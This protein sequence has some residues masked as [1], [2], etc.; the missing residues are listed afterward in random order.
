MTGIGQAWIASTTAADPTERFQSAADA[1][2]SLEAIEQEVG[3]GHLRDELAAEQIAAWRAIRPT[4]AVIERI[5]RTRAERG[6][7]QYVVKT[8]RRLLPY[9]HGQ[10]A[11]HLLVGLHKAGVSND[12]TTRRGG[13][14]G[15]RPMTGGA[16]DAGRPNPKN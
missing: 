5:D 8:A 13:P 11:L 4:A 10:D 12:H 16:S 1:L 2:P 9:R 6:L 14:V 15:R 3:R 7:P